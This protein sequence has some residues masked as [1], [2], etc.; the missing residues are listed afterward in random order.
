VLNGKPQ[1]PAALNRVL[2]E[3]PHKG[4][5]PAHEKVTSQADAFVIDPSALPSDGLQIAVM[6]GIPA[7]PSGPW[8]YK[9]GSGHPITELSQVHASPQCTGS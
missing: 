2:P 7:G 6:R 4:P 5:K 8:P 9:K 1:Q 3:P